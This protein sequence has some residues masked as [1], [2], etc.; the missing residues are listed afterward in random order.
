MNPNIISELLSIESQEFKLSFS[1]AVSKISNDEAIKMFET[2]AY[3][4][5]V[6]QASYVEDNDAHIKQP[7]HIKKL[8]ARSIEDN[9]TSL[10]QNDEHLFRT[11]FVIIIKSNTDRGLRNAEGRIR[12]VLSGSRVF[13]EFPDCKHLDT[14]LNSIMVPAIWRDI[15]CEL[16]SYH[17]AVVLPL[18]SP[19]NRLEAEGWLFGET[20]EENPRPVQIDMKKLAA[21]HMLIIGSSGTGKTYLLMLL[22][23]RALTMERKRVI[24]I[25]P[26]ADEGTSHLNVVK[27]FNGCLIELGRGKEKNINPFEIFTNGKVTRDNAENVFFDHVDILKNFFSALILSET[28]GRDNMIPYLET[29][30]HAV[31]ESKGIYREDPKTWHNFPYLSDIYRL[32]KADKETNP[33]AQALYNKG[34]SILTSWE[35]LNRPSNIDLTNDF[36]V[37]DTSGMRS[38]TD[39][40]QDAYNVLITAMMG[41]R[42]GG[43]GEK[44]TIIC[45]DEARVFLQNPQIASFLMRTL[46]EG[47]SARIG[48][49]LATQNPADLIKANVAEEIQGNM[50]V[51]VVM[52]GM[53]ETNIGFVS[54]FFNLKEGIQK[55]YLGMGKGTGLVMY[56]NKIIPTS[57]KSTT[58]EHQIIKGEVSQ[59]QTLATSSVLTYVLNAL[60]IL[61]LQQKICFDDWLNCDPELLRSKGFSSK[62]GV[63]CM[64]GKNIRI[65]LKDVPSNM[66]DDHF[67]TVCRL[68]GE[69][70]KKGH[71]VKIN[72]HD[73]ADMI[74]NDSIAIEYERPG[75]HSFAELI[76][77][78]DAALQ[79]Y[80]EVWFICQIQNYELIQKAVGADRTITR[81]KNLRDWA[82]QIQ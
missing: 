28:V 62:K 76:E 14:L 57:F 25:T 11:C 63:D 80:Q 38:S 17:A 27:V 33:S 16:F 68:A 70:V 30:I 12:A 6:D 18:Q 66:S 36:I 53:N 47:R 22:L 10:F 55:T 67:S 42:F 39:K 21:R 20:M 49:I 8:Q 23:M 44:E 7:P 46:M 69:F 1:F 64:T 5:A 56:G 71:T 45:V 4:N 32:W 65:W 72:H 24:H 26:K 15:A 50:N 73:D 13:F 54:S 43:H 58:L 74:L 29:T 19:G 48:L 40:L 59:P 51:C 78:R 37:F 31:Y 35:Y 82:D 61:S 77:K 52:G 9:I 3:Y 2:A 34:G 60:Q 75:S 81:G 41:M 79:K